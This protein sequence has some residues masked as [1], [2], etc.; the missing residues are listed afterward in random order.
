MTELPCG[1]ASTSFQAMHFMD[2]IIDLKTCRLASQGAEAVRT[3]E[4]SYLP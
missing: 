4:S 1:D 2:P 3:N